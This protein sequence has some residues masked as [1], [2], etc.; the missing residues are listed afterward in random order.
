VFFFGGAFSAQ[1]R[2]PYDVPNADFGLSDDLALLLASGYVPS[3]GGAT[4]QDLE[5]GA[6][7]TATLTL[8]VAT[9]P[10][11]GTMA[12]VTTPTVPTFLSIWTAQAVA[13]SN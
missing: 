1:T 9:A 5:L 11:Q 2:S 12:I 4:S 7:S 3:L 13:P 10:G 6:L 8:T